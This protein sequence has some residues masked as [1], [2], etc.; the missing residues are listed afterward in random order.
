[1]VTRLLL[2]KARAEVERLEKLALEQEDEN[3]C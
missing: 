3:S 2:A 1:M